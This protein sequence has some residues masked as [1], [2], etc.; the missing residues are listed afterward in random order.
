MNV[1]RNLLCPSHLLPSNTKITNANEYEKKITTL[2]KIN[3]SD[4]VGCFFPSIFLE[5]GFMYELKLTC[6]ELDMK[7][8]SLNFFIESTDEKRSACY[9]IQQLEQGDSVKL[10]CKFY[11]KSKTD[12]YDIYVSF[13]DKKK[14]NIVKSF[15]LHYSDSHLIQIRDQTECLYKCNYSSIVN[16]L[17]DKVYVLNH[18]NEPHKWIAAQNILRL[19]Y[20]I[21]PQRLSIKKNVE[22]IS[23]TV[24]K[25]AH[26]QDS[27][28]C[29]NW[30]IYKTV[31]H[32]LEELSPPPP[33][34]RR[35]IL[36][37]KDD[38]V[39]YM[40]S[41]F[42]S[43][44][45]NTLAPVH[46]NTTSLAAD[47]KSFLSD[48]FSLGVAYTAFPQVLSQQKNVP[49]LPPYRSDHVWLA[50]INAF[51]NGGA[52]GQMN[53]FIIGI[54]IS[55]LDDEIRRLISLQTYP[56]Y[57]IFDDD[58]KNLD[59]CK[60]IFTT[61]FFNKPSPCSQ[62]PNSDQCCYNHHHRSNVA[63]VLQDPEFFAKHMFIHLN[64]NVIATASSKFYSV[65]IVNSEQLKSDVV[66]PHQL[67][68]SELILQNQDLNKVVFIS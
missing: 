19:S 57:K 17:F 27:I 24:W 39:E 8:C 56:F 55:Y 10:L 7:D 65:G 2:I 51:K 11:F 30:C 46:W 32:K 31:C 50:A 9:T 25:K 45:T 28:S 66:S 23:Y 21:L 26:P 18:D 37:L 38:V 12:T 64:K 52:T 1:N 61:N 34:P 42:E 53:D 47:P 20:D 59:L 54:V 68:L 4:H 43:I 16:Q 6:N 60:Y 35:G 22:Q 29:D 58:S 33:A 62:C 63:D 5:S 36:F 41:K 49:N 15:T 44:L 14:S 3:N 67:S 48:L 13:N 40:S